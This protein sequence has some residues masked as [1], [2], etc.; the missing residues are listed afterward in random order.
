MARL[1]KSTG[2]LQFHCFRRE[3]KVKQVVKARIFESQRHRIPACEGLI[4][5]KRS[6][7][8]GASELTGDHSNAMEHLGVASSASARRLFSRAAAQI[9]KSSRLRLL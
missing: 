9:K 7:T 2:M 8:H 5:N 3:Q 4:A 6:A 1:H